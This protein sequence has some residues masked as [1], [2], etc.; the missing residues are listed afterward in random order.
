MAKWELIELQDLAPDDRIELAP[1]CGPAV[2]LQVR[3][4]KLQHTFSV[5]LV[6][7][8]VRL[9]DACWDSGRW[10]EGHEFQPCSYTQLTW[11]DLCGEFI[12]GLYQQSLRCVYCRY[13]CHFRCQPFIQLDCSSHTEVAVGQT[14]YSE[15]IETDTNVDDPVDWRRKELSLTEVQQ[16]I[17]EYN[18]Q[19]NSN[20]YMTLNRGGLYTG[21]IQVQFKLSRPVSLPQPHSPSPSEGAGLLQRRTSFYLPRDTVKKLHVSSQTHV[22]EVITALLHK[23]T[24]LDNPSKYALYERGERHGQVYVR[25]LFDKECPLFLRLCAGPSEKTL[26]FVLRENE[27]GEV[28]WEAFSLPEL[29]NFLRI[30]QREE[31]DH[32]RQIVQRYSLA[33]D[34]MKE[35]IRNFSSPG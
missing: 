13:T 25:K 2:D 9:E 23:F 29:R 32:V 1:P 27:S 35:A 11:C 5:R 14:D 10:G 30:L 31:E 28:N 34:K 24:V 17:K 6:G 15:D 3:S 26:S 19:I 20:L 33:R 4:P 18:A 7:D 21:F 22:R 8:S 16:K 12:W